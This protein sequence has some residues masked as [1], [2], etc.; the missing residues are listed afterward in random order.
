MLA[1]GTVVVVVVV[2]VVVGTAVVVGASDVVVELVVVDVGT[3]VE[4]DV[5]VV[6][7]VV[8]VEVVV[9]VDVVVPLG[10]VVEVDDAVISLAM[11]VDFCFT[12]SEV[13]TVPFEHR[14]V[15]F[16]VMR[17]VFECRH[18]GRRE[19]VVISFAAR[20]PVEHDDFEV[21]E[22]IFDLFATQRIFV[23]VVDSTVFR[24]VFA[25]VLRGSAAFTVPERV[26][27]TVTVLV[28]PCAGDWSKKDMANHPAIAMPSAQAST[29]RR[30]GSPKELF[31]EVTLSPYVYLDE[32]SS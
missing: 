8:V 31:D 30:G 21:R 3:V 26:T 18:T 9:E 28:A 2:V 20:C 32:N 10:T 1:G 4:V 13:G 24:S 27:Q 22:T 5:V 17:R 29:K 12:G 19:V 6:V 15:S 23:V 14:G 25:Q 16:K 7:E 11:L